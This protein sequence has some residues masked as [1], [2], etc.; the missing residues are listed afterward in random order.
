MSLARIGIRGAFF[1][2]L[3]LAFRQ[4]VS[5]LATFYVARQL[6]PSDFGLFSMVMIVIGFAQVIGDVG[7]ATGLVRSQKNSATVLSTCFWVGAAIGIVLAS[8]VFILAPVAGWFYA[9]EEIEPFL[10]ASALGM[11]VNFLTPVPMALLQQR[12]AYKEIALSQGISS[13][14]GAFAAVTLVYAGFGI[15]GLVFQP[16][17]GNLLTLFML[18]SYARWRPTVQF[19]FSSA[20]DI[21]R[22]GVHLLGSGLTG[23]LRNNF[24]TLV[25]GKALSAKDLGVYGMAQTILY[26]PMHLITSTVSRVMFPL[27]SKV[28]DDLEKVRAAVLTAT[29]RTALLVFPLYFGLVML[30][31][32]FVQLVFGPSWLDMVFLIRI[33][34]CSFLIQS[35]G[36]VAG[37]LMLA[38][39]KSKIILR[40][41][42]GNSVLYFVVLLTLIPYGLTA[43]AIGYAITNTIIGVF[44]LGV[45]LHFAKIKKKDYMKS[46]ARPFVLALCMCLVILTLKYF[47]NSAT[48]VQ[49]VMLVISGATVYTVL[50]FFFEKSAWKQVI[51]AIG[52]RIEVE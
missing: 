45:S 50:A 10:R 47:F 39:G 9:K 22:T 27:L 38:L 41:S 48:L 15:W 25:I 19:E 31:D 7:I 29:A 4:V 20:Q 12:L 14:V 24:D 36:A 44:S 5:L 17:V 3:A 32:E 28:Q 1:T 26:A 13:L 21:L 34:A 42:I 30:A 35:I 18:A 52:S 46:I 6:L 49:F 37:P 8:A 16:I 43:V 2:S 11:L 40:I 23:Y 51:S 33:M